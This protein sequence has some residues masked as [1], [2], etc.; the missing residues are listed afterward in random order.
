MDSVSGSCQWNLPLGAGGREALRLKKEKLPICDHDQYYLEHLTDY[1]NRQ[2]DF[3]YTAVPFTRADALEDFLAREKPGFMVLDEAFVSQVPDPERETSDVE[4]AGGQCVRILL[5]EEE[6]D[7]ICRYQSCEEL[8]R[9]LL[10][11]CR[12]HR[13]KGIGRHVQGGHLEGEALPGA[14]QLSGCSMCG[15]YSPV[16]RCGK[17][18]FA[19]TLGMVLAEHKRTLYVNLENYH[20]LDA[21]TGDTG[22]CDL[23]D[24]IYQYRT[25]GVDGLRRTLPHAMTAWGNL[26]CVN[27]AIAAYDL[28]E[29]SAQEWQTLFGEMIL[30][31]DYQALVL[32]IGGQIREV[33]SIL[34]QCT[35]LYVPA[36]SDRISQAKLGQFE[37]NLNAMQME[38]VA[39]K[40]RKIVVPKLRSDS[41]LS[42]FP[43]QLLRGRIGSYVRSIAETDRLLKP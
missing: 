43:R 4:N 10:E 33:F 31:E 28:N 27:P 22:H 16:N 21:F 39:R 30:S 15:V 6:G 20:G 13:N 12:Q 35:H 7:G 25:G 38:E 42:G 29:V 1:L 9:C 3:P 18:I 26:D 34:P 17:T 8:K 37:E 32:D 41:E 23:S 5:C 24:L 19:I 36:L 40:M 2:T 14:E 11:A